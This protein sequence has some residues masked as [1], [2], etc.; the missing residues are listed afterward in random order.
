ML[1]LCQQGQHQ[2]ILAH[3]EPDPWRLGTADRFGEPIVAS[4]TEQGILCPQILRDELKRRPCVVVQ[5]PYQ[6]MVV[7]VGHSTCVQG[8]ANG[9]KMPLGAFVKGV[10]E[11]GQRGNDGLVFRMLAIEHA[12]W[13]SDCSP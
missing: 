13:V 4:T 12:Q 8:R 7:L 2:A 1:S 3:G 5:S 10:P 9:S 11:A 6:P